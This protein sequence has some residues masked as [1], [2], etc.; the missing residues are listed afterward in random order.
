MTMVIAVLTGFSSSGDTPDAT[1][2]DSGTST[3]VTTAAATYVSAPCPNPTPPGYPQF[4]LGSNFTCGYLTVPENRS[5]ADSRTI[6]LLVAT[7]QA[8]SPT[9]AADPIVWLTGGA[10]S[11]VLADANTAAGL[12]INADRDVIF[13]E[14]RGNYSSQPSLVCPEIGE[15]SAALVTEPYLDPGTREQ[16]KA[17]TTACR[18]R[19]ASSGVDLAAY[20]TAENA[21]DIADLRVAMGIAKWNLYGYSYG[22][23][24]ALT[25]LRD[26]PAGVR[27]AVL[28]SVV[29]PNLNLVD[30]FWP[31]G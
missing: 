14:Q 18:D 2:S 17:A 6:R 3:S 11:P 19:L 8:A 13:V 28:D 12:G 4:D 10:G 24:L 5:K 27:S 22:T 9:P 29:P 31:A 15:F 20:S 23:L 21:R 7:L 16:S 25:V 1:R 30:E 26:H